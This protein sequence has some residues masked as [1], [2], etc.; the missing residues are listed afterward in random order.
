MENQGHWLTPFQRKL[1]L[2][3]METD[4]RLEYR[5]R[6][7]IMLL[8][9]QGQSQS[10][11]CAVLGCSQETAR[12]W[13]CIAQ[14]GKAHQWNEHPMGRP[15]AINDEYMNRLKELVSH[16]PQEYG[17]SF[18][19]WTAQW[20]AKHLSKEMGI[21]VSDRHINRLLKE[22]G[23]STRQK[24]KPTKE[25]AD[26]LSKDTNIAINDLPSSSPPNFLWSLNLS[27]TIY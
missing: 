14:A 27:K 26:S 23:L 13:I 11:I 7:E 21:E 10:Q 15:K 22:M 12:Y 1:L 5:R 4:L 2:K 24:S 20:L 6:I 9:D 16:T 18:R 17:Y 8:V 19:Q 25:V 3:S